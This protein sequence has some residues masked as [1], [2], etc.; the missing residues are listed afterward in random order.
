MT[1]LICHWGTRVGGGLGKGSGEV[2]LDPRNH[3]EVAAAL[4]FFM[5]FYWVINSEKRFS[6]KLGYVSCGGHSWRNL[7]VDLIVHG[8][9]G[10]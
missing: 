4:R 1:G 9:V 10:L 7:A 6:S 3:K 5:I 8:D 2:G